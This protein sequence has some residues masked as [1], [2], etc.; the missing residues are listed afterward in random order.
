MTINLVL[1]LSLSWLPFLMFF[2]LRNETKFK[3]NIVIGVTLPFEARTDKDV[4]AV[5]NSFKRKNLWI[6]L[7][8]FLITIS[9]L[10][11]EGTSLLITVWL[12]WV[13]P[14]II[15][16]QIS[17]VRT[18]A[19][20]KR[21]KLERGWKKNQN[22]QQYVNLSSMDSPKWM[23]PKMFIPAVILSFLPILWDRESAL[24]YLVF[25]IFTILF[26]FCYRFLY[27]NKSEMVDQNIQL[28]RVLT[29]VRRYNWGIVWL[30]SAYGF[31]ALGLIFFVFKY[32]FVIQF[33]AF[34]L[35]IILIIV[36]SIRVEF[37]TRSVQEK[38]TAESGKG[39]YVDDDDYW[40]GGIFYHNSN[41]KRL[42]I[43]SRVG[44]NSTINLA[45]T[46][47]KILAMLLVLTLLAMPFTGLY[48]N[49][50]EKQPLSVELNETVL[51]AHR[52]NKEVLLERSDISDIELLDELP[53]KMIKNI[54]TGL[55]KL[56]YGS[57]SAQGIGQIRLC[58]DPQ[59]P[60]FLLV[61]LEDGSHY[62]L[63]SRQPGEI[64]EIYN[65]INK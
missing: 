25:G 16:P 52:G 23:S 48:A 50:L 9:F 21:L 55:E 46:S 43:N 37:K 20:L 44:L 10:F 41:D 12:T 8:S 51:I 19:T 3:K 45:R 64:E 61:E 14:A 40:P 30:I 28:T 65:Q 26:Y 31:A 35:V 11:I 63:G 47:G 17:Y 32:H 59:V 24:L 22:Q 4:L 38:L 49:L 5:L 34:I 58:L 7:F 54:G 6:N 13:L 36:F 27:R 15:I 1:W 2:M 39:W 29:Q 18:N 62:L 42:L 53:E 57:F 33:I 60:P 56:M